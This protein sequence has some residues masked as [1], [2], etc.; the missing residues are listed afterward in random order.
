MGFEARYQAMP[1]GKFLE[2]ARFEVEFA[3]C[4]QFLHDPKWLMSGDEPWRVAA[5][6]LVGQR[7]G[8]VDR[9]FYAGSR[10]FDAIHFLLSQDRRVPPA[11]R[12][13]SDDPH[14][15]A[16]AIYGIE[17]LN[18][19]AGTTQGFPFGLVSAASVPK[20]VRYLAGITE[21]DLGKYFDAKQMSDAA[22]YKASSSLP[23]IWDELQGMKVVYEAA[24]RHGEAMVTMRD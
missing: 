13:I 3:E 10:Q 18:P 1:E 15:S 21:S 9:Y 12:T 2:R 7:P 22:V 20:I 8:L 5:R 19:T 4:I 17:R 24:A 11:G 6:D 23:R 16:K 14:P